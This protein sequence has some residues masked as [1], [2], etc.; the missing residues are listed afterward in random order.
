[1]KDFTDDQFIVVN[2][3]HLE[4]LN[5]VYNSDDGC[6]PECCESQWFSGDMNRNR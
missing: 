5:Q 2:K 1:M 3:K 4:E 6:V